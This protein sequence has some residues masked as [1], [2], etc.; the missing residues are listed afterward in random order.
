MVD[1]LNPLLDGWPGKHTL[2]VASPDRVLGVG[3]DPQRVQRIAS[4]TKL[5]TAYA[6]L[7]AYEEGTLGLDDPAG[8]EGS[9]VRHLLA[10][11]SG[12]PFEGST[13]A[14]DVGDRRIYSNTG[15]EVLGQMTTGL[16]VRR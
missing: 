16:G 7:I 8:P 5:F 15:I 3:G 11:A 13:P 12:L 10:H 4:I 14:A 6:V 1:D 2:A 9:T